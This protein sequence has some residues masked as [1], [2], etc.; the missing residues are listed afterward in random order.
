MWRDAVPHERVRTSTFLTFLSTFLSSTGG[1][2]VALIASRPRTPGGPTFPRPLAGGSMTATVR[3][4]MRVTH[5]VD[6]VGRGVRVGGLEPART[7]H[8]RAC[9]ARRPHCLGCIR[10]PDTSPT[11]RLKGTRAHLWRLAASSGSSCQSSLSRFT[12][13]DTCLVLPDVKGALF[14]SDQRWSRTRPAILA[15]RSSSRGVA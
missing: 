4:F 15:I 2:A 11:C 1:L 3:L 7:E 9:E 5:A 10:A 14:Q 12:Y 6:G 13:I 8:I